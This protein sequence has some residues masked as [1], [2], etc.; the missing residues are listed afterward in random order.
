MILSK[1]IPYDIR[2]KTLYWVRKEIE[3]KS[4]LSILFNKID[5]GEHRIARHMLESLKYKWTEFSHGS[6]EWFLD[7]IAKFAMAESM[8]DFLEN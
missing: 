7:Y 8:L 1:F 3:I 6:P 2:I 4:D 5:E